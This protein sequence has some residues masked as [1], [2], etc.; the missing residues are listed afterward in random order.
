MRLVT[1]L[2]I[3]LNLAS[4]TEESEKLVSSYCNVGLCEYSEKYPIQEVDPEEKSYV[5]RLN[6]IEEEKTALKSKCKLCG[7]QILPN[8]L[9][10][11]SSYHA[12]C[13]TGYRG[14]DSGDFQEKINQW[15]YAK[16]P[17]FF[18]A[19]VFIFEQNDRFIYLGNHMIINELK[20]QGFKFM[21]NIE[22]QE[23]LAKKIKSFPH[24]VVWSEYHLGS[25]HYWAV[26]R[27]H[28]GKT[29]DVDWHTYIIEILKTLPQDKPTIQEFSRMIP[30]NLLAFILWKRSSLLGALAEIKEI[31]LFSNCFLHTMRVHLKSKKDGDEIGLQHEIPFN[32]YGFSLCMKI[33]ED[34]ENNEMNEIDKR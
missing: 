8:Q 15:K 6:K 30:P 26:H 10:I 21:T 25:C 3:L 32:N 2:F 28:Y 19:M 14:L 1:V 11:G 20:R 24:I 7:G 34:E 13:A 31:E 12:L 9:S 33:W 27:K 17:K 22:T 4:D 29:F 23:V 5:I 16:Y 18:D